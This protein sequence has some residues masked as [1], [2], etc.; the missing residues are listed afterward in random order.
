ML[1]VI[2]LVDMFQIIIIHIHNGQADENR[3]GQ[4]N[5]SKAPMAIH[6]NDAG[7]KHNSLDFTCMKNI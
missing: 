1:T 7:N 6:E 4:G 5:E 2:C 3:I